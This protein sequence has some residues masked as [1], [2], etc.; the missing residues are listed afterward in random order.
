MTCAIRPASIFGVGDT[1]LLPGGLSAY[2]KGQTRF[3]V[4]NNENLFDFTEVTNI[5][6]AHHLAAAAL[7]ATSERQAKGQSAPLDTEKVDGEAFFITNDAPVYFFD[8]ARKVWRA[9]GDT[10]KPSQVW[11]LP[12]G[13][14]LFL[15]TVFEW[16]FWILQKGK[17]NLS[18]Q[19]VSFTCMTRYYNID[20]AKKR[21]GYRPVVGL[22]DGIKRGVADAIRRGTVPGM[23]E[24]LKGTVPESAETRKEK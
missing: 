24:H 10:T 6:H 23:P 8:F 21:L 9:A 22:E 15:A 3:Q 13:F 18:R 7:L 4:G 1:Q 12:Q 16:V 5:A 20:K 17:P 14:A 11:V 19:Q 2:Y